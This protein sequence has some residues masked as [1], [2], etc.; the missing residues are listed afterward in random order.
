MIAPNIWFCC[1]CVFIINTTCI[2]LGDVSSF[3]TAFRIFLITKQT[4][5]VPL[6][7]FFPRDFPINLNILYCP[8]VCLLTIGGFH[9]YTRR[10]NPVFDL[11]GKYLI[12][13]N[14]SNTL[15][16]F[17]YSYSQSASSADSIDTSSSNLSPY[18]TSTSSTYH[19][20]KEKRSKLPLSFGSTF[21]SWPARSSSWKPFPSVSIKSTNV[22]KGRTPA[23]SLYISSNTL[24]EALV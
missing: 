8:Y 5:Y 20:T 15:N 11:G 14:S 21:C 13:P 23:F 4:I 17:S 12:L 10:P 22:Y 6:T 2:F 3:G 1:V 16:I 18:G 9:A 19:L 7:E 24:T